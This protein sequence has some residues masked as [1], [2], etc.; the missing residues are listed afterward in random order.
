MPDW[1]VV[2]EE[3]GGSHLDDQR[4]GH[5]RKKRKARRH[6]MASK[7][8]IRCPNNGKTLHLILQSH[9]S[10]YKKSTRLYEPD[11]HCSRTCEGQS[12]ETSEELTKRLTKPQ[13]W[14]NT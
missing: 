11:E 14:A 6:D 4:K 10:K 2:L 12:D 1:I 13:V 7:F 3:K 5:L 8:L 9:A